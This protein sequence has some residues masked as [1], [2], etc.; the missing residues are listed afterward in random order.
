M[1]SPAREQLLDFLPK[2]VEDEIALPARLACRLEEEPELGMWWSR[3]V[4]QARA[5]AGLKRVTVP[6]DLDGRVV[7]ATQ[8]GHRQERALNHLGDLERQPAPDQ[9]LDAVRHEVERPFQEVAFPAPL[10]LDER[11]AKE[12]ALFPKVKAVRH[13]VDEEGPDEHV[14]PRARRAG[15]M[16]VAALILVTGIG[17]GALLRS[18][19]SQDTT[20]ATRS[21]GFEDITAFEYSVAGP[22]SPEADR[23]RHGLDALVGGAYEGS[24]R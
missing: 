4:Q 20:V 9:L 5:L 1:P 10:E 17:V 16:L 18:G 21:L 24:R 23:I 14:D 13:A 11:V 15:P 2:A 12:L 3:R 7:A 19:E 22:N 8:G 6:H